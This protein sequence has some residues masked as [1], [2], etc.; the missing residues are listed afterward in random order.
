MGIGTKD[1]DNRSKEGKEEKERREKQGD[2]QEE[3]V[4]R[5]TSNAKFHD[6]RNM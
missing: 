4:S 2:E 3:I 5:M 1:R 6:T